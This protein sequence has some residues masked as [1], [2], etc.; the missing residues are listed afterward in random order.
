MVARQEIQ[1]APVVP[2]SMFRGEPIPSCE[3]RTNGDVAQC[4]MSLVDTVR[5]LNAR[6]AAAG[7]VCGEK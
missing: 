5:V 4:Y 2:V 6:L 7:K 1:R 3:F